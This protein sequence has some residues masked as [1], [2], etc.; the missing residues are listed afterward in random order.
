MMKFGY[1]YN[2]TNWD[3][4]PYQELIDETRNVAIKQVGI[5]S[6]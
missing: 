1:F 5:L 6:G 3:H 2:L 4:R